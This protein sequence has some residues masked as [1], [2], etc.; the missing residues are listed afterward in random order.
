MLIVSWLVVLDRYEKL[1]SKERW[2]HLE[3][4][5]IREVQRVYGIPTQSELITYLEASRVRYKFDVDAV[6]P[7]H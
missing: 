4:H 5:F 1:L 6:H 7:F 2:Q 3:A